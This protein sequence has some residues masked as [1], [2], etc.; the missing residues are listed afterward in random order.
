[1]NEVYSIYGRIIYTVFIQNITLILTQKLF[2]TN[3]LCCHLKYTKVLQMMT[4][5]NIYCVVTTMNC[6]F[7]GEIKI[8]CFTET[9]LY[10][11]VIYICDK[12]KQEF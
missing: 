6:Y 12:I 9:F 3:E 7:T 11:P 1:M 4:L 2:K 10:F 5:K 8:F